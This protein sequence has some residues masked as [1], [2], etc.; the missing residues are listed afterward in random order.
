ME[1]N[2]QKKVA[3]IFQEEL[4]EIFRKE[5]K[6]HYSGNLITVSEVK[7]T[8]DLSSAKVYLSIFPAN[9]N[10]QI[11]KDIKEKAPLYRSM[12]AKTAAKSM[13]FTPE[14]MFYLDLSLDKI[15]KIERAL[16]GKGENPV[17]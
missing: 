15:E 7:V 13:R 4:S 3:T 1:T 10:D 11:M 8:S 12:I 16:D 6:E 5:A 2:R 17:L 9:N 14:L